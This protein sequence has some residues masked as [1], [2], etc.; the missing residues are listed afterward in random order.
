MLLVD[1]TGHDDNDF[2]NTGLAL[3]VYE[4][5]YNIVS[6]YDSSLMCIFLCI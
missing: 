5:V 3:S 4:D 2:D 1:T 6:E